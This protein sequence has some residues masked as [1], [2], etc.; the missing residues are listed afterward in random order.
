[1]ML[2][3]NVRGLN[4]HARCMEVGSHLKNNKV[5]CAALIETRVKIKKGSV[6]GIFFA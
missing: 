3:W 2:G 6:L 1:M 4:K 5:S